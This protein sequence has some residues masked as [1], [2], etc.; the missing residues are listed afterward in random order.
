MPSDSPNFYLVIYYAD[1]QS[2]IL[3]L[4]PQPE[5]ELLDSGNGEKLERYGKIVLSRPDPQALW[6][7]LQPQLWQ[8]ADGIFKRSGKTGNWQWQHPVPEN[9]Q[10]KF[11]GLNFNI[12]PNAFKHTGIF[13]EQ[14]N[15]WSWMQEIISKNISQERPIKVLNLFAYTGGATVAGALAGAQVVHCDSSK[16]SITWAKENAKISQIPEDR[17]R[18]ILD[19]AKE[20]VRK[21]LKRGSKYDGIILDPPAFGRGADG[22]VW[23]IENDFVDFVSDCQKL[24]NETPLFF[25]LNGYSAGY[26]AIAYQQNI[27]NLVKKFGGQIEFGELTIAEKNSTRVLPCGIFARWCK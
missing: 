19:D 25:L 17:I 12:R 2:Q 23:Q 22:E 8:T 3:S 21:E 13:P 14:A 4:T 9:W 1:M 11:A 24:L 5:Y 6:N 10:I 20:F 7:K 26:S 16:A 18:W 15:N 27:T